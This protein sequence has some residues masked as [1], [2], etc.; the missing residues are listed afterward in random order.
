MS[1]QFWKTLA[2]TTATVLITLILVLSQ[3]LLVNAALPKQ[4]IIA[5]IT[6]V[7]QLT[8]VAPTDYFFQAIQSLTEQYGC[9]IGSDD[10]TFRAERPL[11]RAELVVM[12]NACLSQIERLAAQATV[13]IPSSSEIDT[14]QRLL[15]ELSA[16]VRSIQRWKSDV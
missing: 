3:T 15:N 5:Q 8:D 4:Q 10:G 6:S 9:V 1:K 14:T 12:L 11:V 13:D 16:E 2:F 7:Q